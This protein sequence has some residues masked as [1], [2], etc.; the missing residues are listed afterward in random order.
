M[1]AVAQPAW[2][3]VGAVAEASPAERVAGGLFLATLFVITWEKVHW[4][5]AGTVTLSD[6]VS[7]LFVLS[8]GW[9]WLE[10]GALP[11]RATRTV[12]VAAAFGLALLVVY[13]FGFYSLETGQA[14][15]Q[16]FK[17]TVKFGLHF[18][19]LVAGLAY[20]AA[21]GRRTYWQALTAFC[22]GMLV[23]AAYGVAQLA[24][25]QPRRRPRRDRALAAHRRGQLD[26]HL[27]RR[28]G[29][30]R[31]PAERAHGRPEPPRRDA[32]RAAARADAALPAARARPPAAAAARARALLSA[33]WSRWRRCRE[34][35]CSASPSAC[36]C[37]PSPTGGCS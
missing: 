18:G 23:N 30:G 27:R 8:L 12:G 32:D 9:V 20:L 31:L 37:S 35:A 3:R 4:E 11:L 17:G 21:H 25:R 34:A 22:L 36:S 5:V 33:S 28:R 19:F 2:R 24:V 13:L 10:D 1:S 15:A 26:Q 7:G 16:F 29:P 6:V 14:L